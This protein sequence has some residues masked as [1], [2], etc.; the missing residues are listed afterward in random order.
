MEHRDT[1]KQSFL[2]FYHKIFVSLYLCVQKNIIF[3]QNTN[4]L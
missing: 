4:L 3:A 1:E 2:F